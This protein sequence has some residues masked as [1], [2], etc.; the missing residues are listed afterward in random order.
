MQGFWSLTVY[1]KHHF[2]HANGLDRFSLGTKNK[3]L[4]FADDGSLTLTVGGDAPTEPA[5]LANWLPAP[6]DAFSVYLRAYWPDGSILDGTWAPPAVE[7]VG[8]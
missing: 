4:T 2:F 1:N 3:N 7:R 6:A 5:T 8:G